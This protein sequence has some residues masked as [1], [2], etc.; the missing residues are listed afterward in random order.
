MNHA[1]NHLFTPPFDV[2]T[3]SERKKL[4]AVSQI[5][6]LPEHTAVNGDWQGDLFIVIKGKLTQHQHGELVAG[7]NVGDWFSLADKDG[8]AFDV[9]TQEQSLLYRLDG[10]TVHA[11]SQHNERLRTLL[12][13][14][15]TTRKSQQDAQSAMSQSQQLLYRPVASI[16]EHIRTPNFIDENASLYEA[17]CRMMAVDAKHILVSSPNGVGIF[18]Q[19]DVCRAITKKADFATTCVKDY[20]RFNLYTIHESHDLSEALIT[21]ISKSVH[22]LPIVNDAGE[23]TGV[24]GQTELLNYLTNHSQLITQRIDQAQNLDEVLVGVEMIGTFIRQQNQSG[25]KVHV[26]SRIVQSL[27]IHVFTKVW[28]L[29]APPAV[30]DNTCLIVMGSEGRGEQIMRTD[31]DN[32]LIIRDGFDDPNLPTYAQAFN[33]ALFKLGYP[34]CDGNIMI[35]SPTWRKSLTDFKAQ[36]STWMGATGG[37]M[38]IHFAT[39]MDAHPVCGDVALFYELKSHW[40][41][42]V[43][44][45]HANFINR[46]AAPTLQMASESGFWQKFTGGK[47]SDIDL[48]K[49]G[50]FPIVHGVRALALE[51]GIDETST[52]LRLRQLASQKVI[53]EKTA[54]NITEALEFFLSKR[55]A[56]S[57]IT[58]DKSARKVNPNTLSSLE[59]DLLKESLAV[60][61]YFKGFITRHYRLDVF[62]G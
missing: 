20:S 33:D 17:T 48:K 21:M 12:F 23:I 47:D 39:L 19:T 15:L 8:V 16:G 18:T 57:L 58:D 54:Q 38:M 29:I 60:V 50:I 10:D 37:E 41:H 53:D 49:A 3:T 40:Q 11:I 55:L 32:A 44:H 28:Q 34:Y 35:A 22:R 1:L 36:V 45:A 4:A 5:V 43:R 25:M 31:Q 26:I 56:V 59:R 9:I 51:Y 30:I 27:N 46:F 61:K 2:L 24:I 7:L 6:Y 62:V 52:R 13:A 42:A 14:D